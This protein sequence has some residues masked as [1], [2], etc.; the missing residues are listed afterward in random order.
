MFLG[1]D[2]SITGLLRIAGWFPPFTN[3]EASWLGLAF[4]RA[5]KPTVGSFLET[6]RSTEVGRQIHAKWRE[7]LEAAAERAGPTTR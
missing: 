6:L 7:Q 1:S 4:T 2:D 3:R 5:P